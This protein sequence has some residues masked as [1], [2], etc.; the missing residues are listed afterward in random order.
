M[1]PAAHDRA[2]RRPPRASRRRG[3]VLI[4]ALILSAIIAISLTS[5]IKLAINSV[6]L[7]DRAFYQNAAVNAAEMG[8]ESAMYCYNRLDDVTT[9]TSAWSSSAGWSDP[10]AT[11]DGHVTRT[12]SVGSLGP[13]VTGQVKIYCSN[14][15]G[16]GSNP[17]IVVKSIVSF[18]RGAPMEKYMEMTLRRRS[19]FANG[20]VARDGMAWSGGNV[21]VDSWISDPDN[22]PATASIAY[23]AGVRR[24]RGT[25]GTLSD[26]N[27]AIDIGNGNVYG[28]IASGG[29]TVSYG[30]TAV[31]SGTFP[32]SGV[33]TGR[34]TSD[35]SASFPTITLPSPSYTNQITTSITGTATLP[36]GGHTAASDGKYYY[37]FASGTNIDLNGGGRN[38]QIAGNVVL[39]FNNHANVGTVSLGGNAYLNVQSNASLRVY[40][41]GNVAMGGNGVA[42]A[43]SN[44]ASCVIFGTATSSQTVSISGN[45]QLVA[46]VY[47][48]TATITMN[49]GGSSGNIMGSIVGRTI[50]MTGGSAFHYDESLSNFSAGNPFGI[51]RWR[52]LQTADDRASYS[53]Q[54]NF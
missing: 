5:Y 4:T 16:A 42:N 30:P 24:A 12:M 39:I 35:F 10:T 17:V 52:E 51:I 7:A 34:I 38:L 15:T 21:Y 3:S 47:A 36:A 31:V 8:I 44:A 11:S 46:A 29:G 53:S 19:L 13:G 18:P 6:A 26:T 23:S 33:D 49:G 48:P 32:G 2:A 25:V 14:Y 40:T 50:S 9:P 20:L 22:D 37:N 28:T 1:K 41:N 54:L 43:N 27:G 45:G